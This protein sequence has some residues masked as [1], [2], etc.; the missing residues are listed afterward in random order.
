MSNK[1]DK[2]GGSFCVP[3]YAIH[4]LSKGYLPEGLEKGKNNENVEFVDTEVIGAY[5]VIALCTGPDGI[6]STAGI[7][8][9]EKLLKCGKVTAERHIQA[10]VRLG[11]IEDKR[12]SLGDDKARLTA[13]RFVLKDFGEP[14][15]N[16]V[17]FDRSLV[18]YIDPK[19]NESNVYRLC[20]MG[21]ACIR[22][23]LWMYANQP[24]NSTTVQHPIPSECI[25]GMM[26]RYRWAEDQTRTLDSHEIKV[27][28]FPEFE[29]QGCDL[30]QW[31]KYT[32]LDSAVIKLFKTGFIYKVVMV[33]DESLQAILGSANDLKYLSVDALPQYQLHV[34]KRCGELSKDEV[35]LTHL[36]LKA[37]KY[38]DVSVFTHDGK[39]EDKY[40][41]I[42]KPWQPVS[43]V[44]VYRLSNRVTNTHNHHISE[45]WSSLMD[46]ER[47]YRRWLAYTMEEEY[48]VDLKNLGQT[49]QFE[50]KTRMVLNKRAQ[51]RQVAFR[52]GR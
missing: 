29:L 46:S 37:S 40:V 39:I 45:A 32:T 52:S 21:Y 9:L 48:G 42:S 30:V 34:E 11:V 5:L 18:E 17:W 35:G 28:C 14:I 41:V 50:A 47:A 7:Q 13:V 15:E 16:R 36:T 4:L 8:V 1:T 10:L 12:A 19:S 43:V 44:G 22:I 27:A 23:L 51:P 33:W 25:P 38:A 24:V 26:N 49:T 20:E 3:H 31:F 6:G 2:R